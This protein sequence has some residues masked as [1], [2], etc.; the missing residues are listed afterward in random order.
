ME[1]VIL[2]SLMLTAFSL[3]IITVSVKADISNDPINTGQYDT[4]KAAN[5]CQQKQYILK[6][7]TKDI[8]ATFFYPVP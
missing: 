2:T 7:S 5:Y 8:P 1:K 4:V 6:P 3:M